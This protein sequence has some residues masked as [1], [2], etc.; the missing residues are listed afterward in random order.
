VAQQLIE[1]PLSGRTFASASPGTDGCSFALPFVAGPE[2][3]LAAYVAERLMPRRSAADL[4]EPSVAHALP[5]VISFFGPS[6]T[7]KTHL[8]RGLAEHWQRERGE[9]SAEYMTAADFRHRLLEAMDRDA[10]AEFRRRLRHRRLL[11]LDDVHQLPREAYL[12]EE[13]RHTV[14]D[15]REAGCVVL[16]AARR[17]PH[18]LAN[19]SI[20]VRNRLAEGVAIQLAPPGQATRARLIQ[21]I[22]D[23]TGRHISPMALR[24]FTSSVSGAAN[25]L[26][27]AMFQLLSTTLP[28]TTIS[29]ADIE[30]FDAARAAR[31]PTIGQVIGVVSR[32]FG[33]PQKMLK[34]ASRKQPVVAARA[35][36]I[37]IAREL[38]AAS[39]EQIGRA[40]G[41]RDHSTIMHNYR[42][43]ERQRK[44]DCQTQEALDELMRVLGTP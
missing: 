31:R 18:T 2:N 7:G 37:Y 25:E 27:G 30:Q 32:Y 43:I 38:A 8:L 44:S 6:G 29:E 42:I 24:R 22:A 14:D 4:A 23:A 13:L 34:S 35:T 11:A 26:F 15:C 28:G 40:L 1:L 9:Q 3:R 33:I 36:A 12:M 17:S 20:D 21:Q 19:L 16:V 39:Y 5:A 41:G 10:I